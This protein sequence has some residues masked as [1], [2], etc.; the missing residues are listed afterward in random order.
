MRINAAINTEAFF[1]DHMTDKKFL[2]FVP[3]ALP[4]KI[5]ETPDKLLS[6]LVLAHS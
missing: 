3:Q 1:P 2:L 5:Y 4:E 6:Y